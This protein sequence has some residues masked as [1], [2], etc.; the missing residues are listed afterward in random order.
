MNWHRVLQIDKIAKGRGYRFDVDGRYIFVTRLADKTHAI[1]D[2]CPHK[3]ASLSEG[4][5]KNGYVTCPA[6][7][8]RFDVVD[9]AK[10]GDARTRVPTYPTRIVESWLEVELPPR[11]VERSL[12]EILLAHARGKMDTTG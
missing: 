3:G 2:L 8:W 1:S 4:F 10:Q 5:I 9:G 11:A 7:F 12:R 6:H